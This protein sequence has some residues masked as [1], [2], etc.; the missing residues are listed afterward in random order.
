VR[1]LEEADKNSKYLFAISTGMKASPYINL[2]NRYILPI[3]GFEGQDPFPSL[4]QF[5]SIVQSKE[6]KYFVSADGK[7]NPDLRTASKMNL[8][9]I[10]MWVLNHC[11]LDSKAS[12]REAI[13]DC[14]PS[15]T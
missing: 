14:S 12:F 3:G 2:T 8:S 11:L 6:L 10:E 5:V 1:Y 4:S 15:G 9:S 13:Y 7:F